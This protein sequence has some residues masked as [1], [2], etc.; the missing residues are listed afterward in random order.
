[1]IR[2]SFAG[3]VEKGNLR[4][5]RARIRKMLEKNAHAL[6][7]TLNEGDWEAGLE[8]TFGVLIER[9]YK[10]YQ[11]QVVILID[12]YDKP[13]IDNIDNSD[14][15]TEIRGILKSL[16][17]QIKELSGSIRFAMLTGVSKF[18]QMSLFSGLNN[19]EDIT[20]RAEYSALC[21]YTQEELE[22]V[23]TPELESVDLEQVKHWYRL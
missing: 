22:E 20:L 12:E 11:K 16:Y 21:G 2:L 10:H 3:E 17:S 7:I 9:T 6:Q 19:M 8:Y 5:L 23:F 4:E 18:G 15:A 1:M 13:I 14:I